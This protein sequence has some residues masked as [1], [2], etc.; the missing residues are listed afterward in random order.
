MVKFGNF[1]FHYRN[2]LFPVFYLLL[3]IPSPTIF[4]N[5]LAAIVAGICISFTGELIRA[6]VMGLVNIQHGGRDR[7]IYSADLIT[8]GIFSHCRNPLY[9]GNILILLGLGVAANSLL[10]ILILIPLFIFFYQAIVIAE[11]DF[12]TKNFGEP[13]TA[14]KSK[15]NRWLPDL[16]GI[17]KTFS[18]MH[19]S[20]QRV[21][22]KEYNSTY[23]WMSCFVLLVMKFYWK[24][25]DAAVY[26]SLPY[27]IV[28]LIFL[29]LCYLF[30][31]YMKKSKR[32]SAD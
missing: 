13:Y 25:N 18:S 14:Y 29:L 7:N 5:Y 22:V 9:I 2:F 17:G 28:S 30:I 4:N 16:N 3:F 27:L 26:E 31:R 32:W 23:L 8:D 12:L 24:K 10:F 15:V 21:L 11:E 1:I 20:I 19:F 6:L